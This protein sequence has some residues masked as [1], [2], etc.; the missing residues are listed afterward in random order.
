V[1]TPAEIVARV[2][3]M[4][5][6][7]STYVPLVAAG[8]GSVYVTWPPR[9]GSALA[10]VRLGPDGV[11][12]APDP[13]TEP[14]EFPFAVSIEADRLGN[15]IAT[16]TSPQRGNVSN[17][18]LWAAT[19]GPQ[20]GWGGHVMLACDVGA[21]HL[22]VGPSGHATVVW[23]NRTSHALS[24]ARYHAAR[25]WTDA[26]ALTA[27]DRVRPL[28]DV[29]VDSNGASIVVWEE[30]PFPNADAAVSVGMADRDG[31][32]V[33]RRM[34]EFFPSQ[35]APQ[36]AFEADGFG[37]ATWQGAGIRA[38]RVSAAAAHP[39]EI[40]GNN[41]DQ[42]P[43][44]AGSGGGESVIVWSRRRSE[45]AVFAAPGSNGRWEP[46]SI[47]P[48]HPLPPWCPD[49]AM[50]ATGN[51][52]VAWEEGFTGVSPEVW[53]RARTG[54]NG[55]WSDPIRLGVGAKFPSVAI[56][57]GV[58]HVVWAPETFDAVYASRVRLTP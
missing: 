9:G 13:V 1:W 14:F 39:V 11:W 19:T 41:D 8:R 44:V 43:E 18:C 27:G 21:P 48:N 50:D 15:A 34:A 3:L 46:Q 7:G 47:A 36:V 23:A 25:G 31:P 42:C 10:T 17:Q 33:T 53:A 26:G 5:S 29:A 40:S 55:R 22:A 38:A 16:W 32:W 2:P 24:S 20:R 58:A 52:V 54:A 56:A 45:P 30:R 57:A 51:A 4:P 49:V 12:A 35:G 6:A 28:F 37:V